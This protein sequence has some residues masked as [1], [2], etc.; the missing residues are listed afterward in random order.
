MKFED[1]EDFDD[2]HAHKS[3]MLETKMS[4][5]PKAAKYDDD[6]KLDISLFDHEEDESIDFSSKTFNHRARKL[7]VTSTLKKK[8]HKTAKVK[9]PDSSTLN[10]KK[11]LKETEIKSTS[12]TSFREGHQIYDSCANINTSHSYA[13]LK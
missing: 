5:I 8:K 9:R 1:V 12:S 7:K 2:Q 13:H 4:S 11:N 3:I 10:L 6:E